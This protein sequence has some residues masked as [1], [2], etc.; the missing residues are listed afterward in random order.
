M[1][2]C[3]TSYGTIPYPPS[4]KVQ[5]IRGVGLDG[6]KSN[7]MTCIVIVRNTCAATLLL[8]AMRKSE[9]LKDSA[10][11][12]CGYDTYKY[13]AGAENKVGDQEVLQL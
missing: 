9:T 13:H 5:S 7:K 11:Q 6:A 2:L 8:L 10:C 1:T 3:G 12:V 4:I